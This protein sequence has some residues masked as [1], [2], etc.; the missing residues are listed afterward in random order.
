MKI[1]IYNGKGI[2]L[3]ATVI[4][5]AKDLVEA[6][7]IIK[8]ELESSGLTFEGKVEEVKTNVVY[9]DDGDY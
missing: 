1:Y 2:W 9:F 6:E 5:K 4:V 8:A 7:T 3:G